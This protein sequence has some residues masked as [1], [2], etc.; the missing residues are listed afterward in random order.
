MSTPRWE[1]G[2]LYAP[3]ALVVPRTAAP[4]GPVSIPNPGFDTDAS[5]WTLVNDPGT[6]LVWSASGGYRSP[7]CVVFN[8]PSTLDRDGS[9]TLASSVPVSAGQQV[10]VSAYG[11]MTGSAGTSFQ[12]AIIW[13]SSGDTFLST[14]FG[15]QI[16][17]KSG[18]T[19]WRT[20]TAT[21]A[22][23]AG[24]VAMRVAA[25][26]NGANNSTITIDDFS[27]TYQSANTAGLQYKAVQSAAGYSDT[28]EPVWPTTLGVTVVDNEVTWEAVSISRVV[29]EA[30]P[31]LQSD[32]TEPDWP[33]VVGDHV[34]DGSISWEVVARR[35][36][37]ENCPESRVTAI[38]ASKVFKA[39]K[40][41]VRFSATANPFDWTTP[42]DAGYL[43]TG[44]QQANAN[45]MLVLQP[46]RGCLTA[47]NASSFQNW[48]VDPDPAAMALLD[49]MDGVGSVWNKAACAVGNEL[50]YLS[51]LG[52]RS[53]G[54]ATASTN[55]QAGDVGSHIDP[56]VQA[57][58]ANIG[59]GV[60]PISTYYPSAGQYWLAFKVEGEDP[61]GEA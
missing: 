47:F 36:E 52:V 28:T 49:Q 29:W 35:V 17:I 33:T 57:A 46:Y 58:L 51:Q 41:I 59:A 8:E 4:A 13:Y 48:Q 34:L 23:P 26:L 56:L 10:S 12:V 31:L 19:G 60:V 21:A 25:F 16:T 15:T 61:G 37:D 40:D 43:P 53:V 30:R 5:G 3:G 42:D 27:W 54:I 45:D 7:G 44:L 22:A 2:K 18:G 1:P 6:T 20:S 11:K 39:D 50:F 14:A 24:A 55:L 38:A 9:I 32:G